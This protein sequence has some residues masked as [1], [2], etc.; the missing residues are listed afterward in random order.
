M[1]KG[2]INRKKKPKSTLIQLIPHNLTFI[3]GQGWSS[4]GRELVYHSFF[5]VVVF[6]FSRQGSSI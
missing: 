2:E 1:G 3:R 5:V 4:F 6:G